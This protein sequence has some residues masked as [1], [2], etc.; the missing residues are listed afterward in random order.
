MEFQTG[1]TVKFSE[2]GLVLW[3]GRSEGHRVERCRGWKWQVVR[4]S[5]E[6]TCLNAGIAV[7]CLRL[8]RLGSKSSTISSW[9]PEYFERA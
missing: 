1:D 2:K 3:C 4:L 8:R 6:P 9:S 7:K 5:K